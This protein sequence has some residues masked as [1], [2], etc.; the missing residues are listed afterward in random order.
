[1]K[2]ENELEIVEE[3]RNEID[4]FNS[5]NSKSKIQILTNI[6]DSKKLYNLENG[7]VT[8]KI[9]DLKGTEIEVVEFE[10]KRIEK[11]LNNPIVDEE[12]GEIVKDT[13]LKMITILLDKEGNSYVTASSIFAFQFLR[14]V[15]IIGLEKFKDENVKIKII[16]KSIKDSSNKSLGFEWI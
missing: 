7:E 5:S 15:E 4:D 16:E 1:M 11:K 8:Y 3:S 12:S 6:V 10:V 2:K 13:E 9:N 14:L